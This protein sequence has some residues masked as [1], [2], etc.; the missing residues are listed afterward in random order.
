MKMIPDY[1]LHAKSNAES[2]VFD[3]L[4]GILNGEGWYAFHSLNLPRHQTKRFGEVDFVVCGPGGLF[5]FEVKGGRISCHEG[6]WGTTNA[7]D[8]YFPLK[9]PPYAQAQGAL[10]G[11]L[12]KIEKTMA[13][14]FVRGYGVITPDCAM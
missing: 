3:K 13:E 9:E 6:N 12:E 5:A 8:S 2:R 4:R 7:N 11:V 10:F 14:R 1:L